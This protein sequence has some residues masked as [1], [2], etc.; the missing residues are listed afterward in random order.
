MRVG[1]HPKSINDRINAKWKV[2]SLFINH[3]IV[4]RTKKKKKTEKTEKEKK[5]QK[6]IEQ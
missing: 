4:I 3:R 2:D 5:K 6:Q 1:P